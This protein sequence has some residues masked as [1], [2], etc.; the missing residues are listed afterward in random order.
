[1][2]N[3]NEPENKHLEQDEKY[4]DDEFEEEEGLSEEYDKGSVSK[5]KSDPW[6]TSS[7]NE[8]FL[9][10]TGEVVQLMNWK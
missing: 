5:W 9:V 6:N 10:Q 2:K 4:N 3:G 1:M 7:L 8:F